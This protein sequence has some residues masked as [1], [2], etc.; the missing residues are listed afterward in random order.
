[1]EFKERKG[2][3]S[4]VPPPWR[5]RIIP[6]E[7][8]FPACWWLVSM[9][10]SNPCF[11]VSWLRTFV[12]FSLSLAF[13]PTEASKWVLHINMAAAKL[14]DVHFYG[15]SKNEKAETGSDRAE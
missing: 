4:G 8:Q 2:E 5:R 13:S 1:M 3:D 10:V 15:R 12:V 9:K 11:V 6:T 14:P 7:I